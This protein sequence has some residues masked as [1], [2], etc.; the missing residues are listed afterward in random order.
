LEYGVRKQFAKIVL[1]DSKRLNDNHEIECIIVLPADLTQAEYDR[2][3]EKAAGANESKK[4]VG[5]GKSR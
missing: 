4:P 1:F 3:S 2:K 5:T